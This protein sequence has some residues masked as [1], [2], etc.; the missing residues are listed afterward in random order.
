VPGFFPGRLKKSVSNSRETAEAVHIE[1]NR[2]LSR[3]EA[4]YLISDVTEQPVR[5][6]K[7]E[8][9]KILRRKEKASHTQDRNKSVKCHQRD[10]NI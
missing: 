6:P 9:E 8:T 10:K 7:G 3:E 4:G 5:R 2:R 1:K